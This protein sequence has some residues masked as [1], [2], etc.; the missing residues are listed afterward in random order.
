[1]PVDRRLQ[2]RAGLSAWV[3]RFLLGR[4]RVRFQKIGRRGFDAF[5]GLIDSDE[6][7]LHQCPEF[8]QADV[9]TASFKQSAADVLFEKL[10]RARQRW[11][12]HAAAPCGTREAFLFAQRKKIC[13][14]AYFHWQGFNARRVRLRVI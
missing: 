5:R 7:R 1:M 9:R 6:V 4:V 13:D 11:L 10:Y 12:G 14:M 2:E 8:G 3:G